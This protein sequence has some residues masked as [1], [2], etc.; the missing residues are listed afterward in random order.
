[1]LIHESIFF[2]T[3]PILFLLL[4]QHYKG[5]VKDS[6]KNVKALFQSI[7]SLV[8]SLICLLLVMY[9]VGSLEVA[10]DIWHSWDYAEFP[11]VDAYPEGR[12]FPDKEIAGGIEAI[13]WDKDKTEGLLLQVIEL[14]PGE[15]YPPL[16]FIFTI[17][18]IYFVLFNINKLDFK[19]L[20]VKPKKNDTIVF[21]YILALQL[22]ALLPL[23]MIAID[24]GRWIYYWAVTSFAIDYLVSRQQVMNMLPEWFIRC[25]DFIN[26]KITYLFGN[27]KGVIVLLSLFIGC[28]I[29]HDLFLYSI[30]NSSLY[31][32][33]SNFSLLFARFFLFLGS[34]I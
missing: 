9:Y 6:Y 5:K 29:L 18:T 17:S 32:A 14:L 22:C 3:F 8:P 26:Q 25:V 21:P 11:Y 28:Y 4:F 27:S 34:L 15:L 20:S 13:T 2:I 33:L 7:L 10:Y 19:I 31:I 23:F 30:Y 24:Y 1:M 16:I 12:M